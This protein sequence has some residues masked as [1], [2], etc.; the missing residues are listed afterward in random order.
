MST[1]T[2]G[3]E[4]GVLLGAGSNVVDSFFT[5]R[6]LPQHGEK[7]YFAGAAAAKTS[8]GGV[9]LNHLMWARMLNVPSALMALQVRRPAAFPTRFTPPTCNFPRSPR[10]E[11]TRTASTFGQLCRL[12]A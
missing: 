12:M 8:V 9:T 4:R 5:V 11:R 6:G 2:H 10:R 3:S 7:Q 1:A